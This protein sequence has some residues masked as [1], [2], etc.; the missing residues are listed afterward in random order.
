MNGII[1]TQWCSILTSTDCGVPVPGS[2]FETRQVEDTCFQLT[3][4]TGAPSTGELNSTGPLP[5]SRAKAS[6]AVQAKPVSCAAWGYGNVSRSSGPN[7]S[8]FV[9]SAVSKWSRPA[10]SGTQPAN[11]GRAVKRAKK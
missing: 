10:P 7:T 4:V 9:A 5:S 2:G 8:S 1:R 3:S 6:F 11:S